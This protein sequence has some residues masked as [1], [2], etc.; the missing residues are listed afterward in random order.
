MKSDQYPVV[1]IKFLDHSHGHQTE[2]CVCKVWGLLY[3]QDEQYYFVYHWLTEGDPEDETNRE[4][5]CI[6][7]SAVSEI[8]EWAM[9]EID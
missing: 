9:D 1:S 6:L 2:P 5:S 3:S 8:K 4:L 7:K